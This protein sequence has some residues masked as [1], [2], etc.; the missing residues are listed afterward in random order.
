MIDGHVHVVGNGSSGSGATLSL[1][2]P[3]QRLLARVLLHSIGLPATALR[4]NLDELYRDRLLEFI[5][6]SPL[7]QV[8]LLAH[9]HAY[10]S[11]GRLLP[12][13]GSMYVPNDYVL[14]L[15]RTNPRLL[16]GVS[17]HP[18]RSDAI[19]ELDRCVDAGAVLMKCLPNCQNIDCSS[20]AYRKFWERMAFH[21]LPLLAHTGGELSLPVFNP[22][23]A[24]PVLLELPLQCGVTVIAAHCGT[25]SHLSD[26]DYLPPFI[27]L[28]KKHPRLYG[29]NSGMQ[30]PFRSAH[31]RT[32]LSEPSMNR[33]VHG[34]D[35]PIPVSGF[36]SALRRTIT[37]SQW[38]ETRRIPN[39]LTRDIRIKQRMG[40]PENSFTQLSDLLPGGART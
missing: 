12:D 35:Y 23:F 22:R 26:P 9:E 2:S 19:R 5:D 17:I 13:F 7:R 4:G 30:T 33:M 37:W 1:R 18:A 11:E 3:R 39:P 40:F 6:E 38:H 8:V 28:L 31:F 36:W 14:S 24:D 15:T 25:Q 27:R 16:A 10:T 29:D 21:R 34:S 32:L 20:P